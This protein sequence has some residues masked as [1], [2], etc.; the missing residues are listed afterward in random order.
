MVVLALGCDLRIVAVQDIRAHHTLRRLGFSLLCET[1]PG[2]PHENSKAAPCE[3]SHETP[4]SEDTCRVGNVPGIIAVKI[5]EVPGA[6]S[7]D[8]PGARK[9]RWTR[10]CDNESTGGDA[11][12]LFFDQDPIL[13]PD[14]VSQTQAVG[15]V[16]Y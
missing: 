6:G 5:G 2:D 12:L 8:S 7:K 9:V 10:A 13:T 1:P 15:M 16:E 4:P 11:A 14:Y 3:R